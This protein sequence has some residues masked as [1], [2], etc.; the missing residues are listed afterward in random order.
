MC[1][2]VVRFYN[3]TTLLERNYI[4][5]S[6]LQEAAVYLKK[7]AA[8]G[9]FKRIPCHLS[10]P[11][12]GPDI[13]SWAVQDL[14]WTHSHWHRLYSPGNNPVMSMKNNIWNRTRDLSVCNAGPQPT[15]PTL[16]E[17]PV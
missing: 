13:V 1:T 6:E 3:N 5:C 12:R 8:D 4:L 17:A 16:F 2:H 10:N 9:L 7:L 11:D 14:W 15:A